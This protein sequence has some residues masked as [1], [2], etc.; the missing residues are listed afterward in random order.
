MRQKYF[1]SLVVLIAF[2]SCGED[3]EKNTSISGEIFNPQSD[4]VVFMRNNE[5]IDTVEIG[6]NNRF[7]YKFDHEVEKGLYTILHDY[8]T[9]YETQM[10][11]LEKGD[12]LQL[13]LN[14]QEFDQSLM[15][16]GQGAIANNFL[17]LLFLENIKNRKQ[18]LQYYKMSPKT[19]LMK[20]DS[21][22]KDYEN[23]LGVLYSK[24]QVTK[25]FRNIA[26]EIIN[27]SYYNA[28][29]RYYF[30]INK[31]S[32]DKKAELPK[33]YFDYR[34]NIDFNNEDLQKYYIY[35]Y[36]L[37]DYLKNVSIDE[38]IAKK[39]KDCF[40][41]HAQENLGRRLFL[42][43]SL[44]DLATLR[45]RF[46]RD[47]GGS[48]IVNSETNRE[49]DST[50]A[51]LKKANFSANELDRVEQLGAVHKSHFIGDVN[52]LHLEKPGGEVVEIA[53]L[54]DK[55]TVFYYWSLYFKSHHLDQHQKVKQFQSR[56]PEVNFVGINI[57]FEE[58]KADQINDWEMGLKN[59]DY[60]G[61]NEYRLICKNERRSFYK[62][63]LNKAVFVNPH[64]QILSGNFSLR[65]VDFEEKLLGYLNQMED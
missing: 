44:F 53:A 34:K 17:M 63:Y 22:K 50:I 36:F 11:Y 62:S 30:L 49:V 28:C 35:H 2:I 19:F 29:E 47:F 20:A 40:N 6:E 39:G 61:F 21:I 5:L 60:Q 18:L 3:V 48:I 7:Y 43:D 15:Y 4:F 59:F 46:L 24:G 51:F 37:D 25:D 52:Q 12:S 13:R 54:L 32:K 1:L 45:E 23:D 41:L 31:Y 14:T 8:N 64:G 58:E 10:F 42:S 38:C 65:D 26:G 55:P 56:Y 9:H 27:Y 16:T 33:D 57:D